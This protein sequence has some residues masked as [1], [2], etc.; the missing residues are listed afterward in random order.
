M[1][2]EKYFINFVILL[3]NMFFK[4]NLTLVIFKNNT[5]NLLLCVRQISENEF[6]S[7]SKTAWGIEHVRSVFFCSSKAIEFLKLMT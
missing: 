2:I 5:I 7:Q 3:F 6:K 4:N 1:M